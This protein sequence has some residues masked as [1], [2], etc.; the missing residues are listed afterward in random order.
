LFDRSR[1]YKS[2]YSSYWNWRNRFIQHRQYTQQI[3]DSIA[4]GG[5]SGS[6]IADIATATITL[7]DNTVGT[8]VT[9]GNAGD[10]IF[11]A[12]GSN[13]LI[14]NCH[15]ITSDGGLIRV[16][17]SGSKSSSANGAAGGNGVEC[18][19]N[20]NIQILNCVVEKTGNGGNGYRGAANTNPTYPGSGGNGGN[21]IL[22]QANALNTEIRNCDFT[23]TGTGGL[24]G[25]TATGVV[26]GTPGM[27][28]YDL[29]TTSAIYENFASDIANTTRYI[30]HN[31][32]SESGRAQSQCHDYLD[33]IY[34]DGTGT[35]YR[36]CSAIELIPAQYPIAQATISR[37]PLSPKTISQPG[38][39]FLNENASD[40]TITS[41]EVT[42][43]L[44][45]FTVNGSI[46]I[47]NNTTSKVVIKNGIVDG[48]N[49]NLGTSNSEI[50]IEDIVLKSGNIRNSANQTVN[51]LTI[52][53]CDITAG[54]IAINPSGGSGTSTNIHISNCSIKGAT[55]TTGQVSLTR[56]NYVDIDHVSIQSSYT[57]N[58][59]NLFSLTTCTYV[60]L[61]HCIAT[62]IT[63]NYSY[64]FKAPVATISLSRGAPQNL[65][66]TDFILGL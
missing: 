57:A 54:R 53:N 24:K 36:T 16:I 34:D 58:N 31:S 63:T 14:G 13:G 38:S 30:I 45:G 61:N 2:S 60:S 44:N 23:D 32:S 29:S 27:A 10:A 5:A 26:N 25:G 48:G 7:G 11:T 1:K 66:A 64:G 62:G 22:V 28:I 8:A 21:E 55:A 65:F 15:F 9:I 35:I 40:I 49:I 20:T 42:I 4:T 18:A 56:C 46:T 12:N 39:Y 6:I 52:K 43:D 33:N 37:T 17:T 50:L 19:G 41:S 3:T 59:V 47:N 51:N